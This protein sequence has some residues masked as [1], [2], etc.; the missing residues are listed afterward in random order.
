[1]FAG[2]VVLA[3]SGGDEAE[4]RGSCRQREK[5]LRVEKAT[6]ARWPVNQ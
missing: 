3:V 1:M 4:D 5:A 6:F 2:N